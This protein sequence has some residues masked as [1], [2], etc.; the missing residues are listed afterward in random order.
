MMLKKYAGVFA[1]LLLCSPVVSFSQDLDSLLNLSAFTAESELQKA[2][3][4]GTTVSSSK[5]LSLRETPGIISVMS[6]EEIQN[7]GARD[8]T[9]LLR[10]IPGFDIAQDL[11]F[12][13][14]IA[15]RGNWSNEGKV[16]VLMDGQPFNELLYQTVAIGNRFPVDGIERIEIIRGPGSAIYGGSAE[17]GVI[18]IVTKAAESLNGV[19]VYGVGG[20]HAGTVGRTNAGLMLA[21]RSDKFAIDASIF[22][23]KGIVSDQTFDGY[24]LPDVSNADPMNLNFGLRVGGL[25]F[26]TMYDQY[27]TGDPYQYISYNNFYSDLRYTW[28]ASP[29]LS[30]IPQLKY[31]NQIPWRWGDAETGEPEFESR[32]TRMH[33][34]LEAIYDISR[35]VNLNFGVLYYSDQATDLLETE[36][37]GGEN[38]FELNNFAL[39]AQSI[40]KHRLFN[41]TVGFRYEKSN[42]YDAAFVP[43]LALTKKIENFHFKVLYSQAFR[44]PSIQN[45]NLALTGEIKPEKSNVFEAEFGYQF[46]PE[47]LLAVNAYSLTTSNIL[48]YGSEGSGSDFVEWY[49]NATKMGTRGLELIYNIRKSGWYANFSYSFSQAIG[50]DETVEPYLVP[51]TEKQYTGMLAHKVTLNSSFN[52]SKSISFNPSFIYGGKRYAFTELDENEE[53]VSTTLDPYLLANAFLN[54]KNILPGLTA[55]LGVYDILNAQPAVPQ[56]YNG[57]YLPIPARSREYVVK[58]SYRLDFKK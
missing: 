8:L 51:Q 21:K 24:E 36:M 35:K 15:L 42:R 19:E 28:K 16:L 57:G 40:V 33:S 12:V 13:Q 32:A 50:G 9:D 52:I 3:N 47:M 4:K 17:Y 43:R 27:E 2:L 48:T 5:A 23:G 29:K 37:F 1:M 38:T 49:D 25:S 55:G 58:L 26:R 54:F 20:F 30:V 56:A 53:G 10:L 11:Q 18:N 22:K 39:F 14:G 45:I 7:T 31:Y 6:S 46:T 44:A 34:Q 41:A